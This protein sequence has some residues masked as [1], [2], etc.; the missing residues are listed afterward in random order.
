MLLHLHTVEVVEE[1]LGHALN[2]DGV[3]PVEEGLRRLHRDHLVQV[4]GREQVV[5]HEHVLHEDLLQLVL[6]GVHDSELLERLQPAAPAG[7]APHLTQRHHRHA[8]L[9]IM[10]FISAAHRARGGGG[11]AGAGAFEEVDLISVDNSVVF[12]LDFEVV[13]D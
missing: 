7:R 10:S 13:G 12:A 5:P 11:A 9:H 4:L 3:V 1:E 6:V 2:D 8:L